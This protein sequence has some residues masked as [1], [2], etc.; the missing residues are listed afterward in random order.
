MYCLVKIALCCAQRATEFIIFEERQV[1]GISPVSTPTY[2][3]IV[4]VHT[5]LPGRCCGADGDLFGYSIEMEKEMILVGSPGEGG[6]RG[7]VY[8]FRNTSDG[9]WEQQQNK[10]IASDG[11]TDDYFGETISFDGGALV[12]GA[13]GKQSFTGSIY[14]FEYSVIQESFHEATQL[15]A[16]NSESGSYF[17]SSVSIHGDWIGVGSPFSDVGSNQD[18]GSVFMFEYEAMG[19]KRS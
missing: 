14:I 12:V 17:G 7:S 16:P 5:Y 6:N 15:Q 2:L 19:E 3:P 18:A 11:Q 10:I 8:I 9:G 13:S 1:S 4:G